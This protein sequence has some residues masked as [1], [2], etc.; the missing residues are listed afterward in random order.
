[1]TLMI[2]T[3]M[4]TA[5]VA[6]AYALLTV[7]TN[8][9]GSGLITSAEL[10]AYWDSGC[11]TEATSITF[12]T[13]DP[14]SSTD[15]TVYIRNEGNTD[16]TLSMTTNNWSPAGATTYISLTWNRGGQTISPGQVITCTLTLTVSP[17]IQNIDAFSVNIII[18]GTG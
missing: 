4:A 11:T 8:I 12:G 7:Q 1:M 13:L 14:G 10:G 6:S 15:Y 16:L 17:S 18:T 2:V 5:S 3:L 9:Q